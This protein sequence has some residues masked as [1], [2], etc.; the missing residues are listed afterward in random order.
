M[1]AALNGRIEAAKNRN[2]LDL[3][4]AWR[5][6]AFTGAAFNGKLKSFE[7]YSRQEDGPADAQ[8]QGAAEAVAFFHG[9]KARGFDVDI[10][11]TVN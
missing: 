10:T 4:L 2:K 6:G 3:R 8:R 11:R 9:L 5:I 7:H 1:V